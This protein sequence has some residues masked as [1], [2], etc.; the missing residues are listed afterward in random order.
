MEPG[1]EDA[2]ALAVE[3]HRGQ[4]YPSTGARS[5][6]FVLHPLRVM[7]AVEGELQRV[8]AVLHDVLEDT[9]CSL[10]DLRKVA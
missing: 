8:V 5:E 3:A 7:V 6:P 2:I 4:C 10:D 9:D 1:L